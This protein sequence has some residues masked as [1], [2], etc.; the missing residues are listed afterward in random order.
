MASNALDLAAVLR[1]PIARYNFGQRCAATFLFFVFL[2]D[3][4]KK[5]KEWRKKE[6]FT[7]AFY[8]PDF[9]C[10][11]LVGC[12]KRIAPSNNTSSNSSNALLLAVTTRV[13][14]TQEFQKHKKYV[15]FN[16]KQQG[17]EFF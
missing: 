17:I 9:V 10:P 11:S 13:A 16:M 14:T 5:E 6:V 2:L 4:L 15:A 7:L 1:F 3:N 8:C 12:K